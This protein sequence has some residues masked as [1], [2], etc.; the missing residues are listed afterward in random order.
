M[1]N[2]SLSF[3]SQISI[4][5]VRLLSIS[6]RI[7]DLNDYMIEINIFEDIFSNF[8]SGQMLISDSSNLI[9]DMPIV[10]SEYLQVK[11]E[12]PTLGV[13]IEKVF[14][15][16]S[17]TDIQVVR[18]NNT[19]TYILHFTSVEAYNDSRLSL[20][21]PFSGLVTDVVAEIYNDF[22]KAPAQL[23][24]TEDK[25]ELNQSKTT[26][27]L[28]QPT[29]NKVKFISPGWSPATCIN[30]LASKSVSEDD[31]SPDYLFWE[32]TSA[33]FIFSSIEN[34]AKGYRDAGVTK[35]TYYYVPQGV[36]PTEDVLDKLFIAQ[37]FEVVSFV[38]NLKNNLQGYFS[39]ALGV[40]DVYKKTY[41]SYL[42]NHIQNYT[43]I[44][45]FGD[46]SAPFTS[47]TVSDPYQNMKFYSTNPKLFSGISENHTV[48]TP[49]RK[50]V[51]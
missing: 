51:V 46:G 33:G 45:H 31:G 16:Y 42:Y 6:G 28:V 21:K 8:L 50:S 43:N 10:G 1:F 19:R 27:L 25:V 7:V 40:Y 22:L 48:I 30:W 38:D 2:N 12:T 5:L 24:F 34:I 49:D 20:F 17:V 35:G 26:P 36:F 18:D 11:F 23:K 13:F 4:E 37:D 3:P 44:T 39:N 32:S 29:K 47:N 14:R 15:V 41:T 9:G